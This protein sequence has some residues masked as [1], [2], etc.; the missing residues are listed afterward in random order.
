MPWATTKYENWEP[1][2]VVSVWIYESERYLDRDATM[3]LWWI[4]WHRAQGEKVIKIRSRGD[5]AG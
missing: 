2:K 3:R 4:N 1:V 5:A